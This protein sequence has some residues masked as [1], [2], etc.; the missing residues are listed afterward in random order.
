MHLGKII[1]IQEKCSIV[2]QFF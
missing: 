2:S 1:K